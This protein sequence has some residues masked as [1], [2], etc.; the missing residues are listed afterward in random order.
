MNNLLLNRDFQPPAD[1]FYQVLPIGRFPIA[2]APE[3]EGGEPRQLVQVLDAAAAQSI[4][5]RFAEAA[6]APAFGGLLVDYDHFSLD[7]DKSSAAAGW[8][9]ELQNRADGVY[10]KI[11]WSDEGE[12]A[13]NGGRYRYCSPVFDLANCED[14]GN[15]QVRPL[16]L[17]NLALTNDP[18]L[19]TLRPLT[20]RDTSAGSAGN[21]KGNEGMDKIAKALGL[22]ETA[23][24]EEIQTALDAKLARLADLEGKAAETQAEEDMKPYE[25][26]IADKAAMKD[27]LCKNRDSGL[28]M[29]KALKPAGEI[30]PLPNRANGKQPGAEGDATASADE[31]KAGKIRNRASELQKSL[32]L[33]FSQA[34]DRAAEEVG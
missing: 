22:A 1:G 2:L 28:K 34:W 13:V 18:R 20:N 32:K 31:A 11:R 9:T 23:T 14:L 10:A 19:K 6:K 33:P 3:A 15:G 27:V 26:Q 5:N 24:P 12:L 30:K 8:I 29:L 21:K 4:C 7:A 25:G 16:S 17:T